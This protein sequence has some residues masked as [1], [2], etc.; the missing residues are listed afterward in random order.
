MA[1]A[2][3][4]PPPVLSQPRPPLW[5]I[6]EYLFQDMTVEVLARESDLRNA[7]LHGPRGVK[8]FGIDATAEMLTGGRAAA[9][10][11][12]YKD[13]DVTLIR[14]ACDEF[15]A[16]KQHW[17]QE[18]A[19]RFIVVTAGYAE[20]PTVQKEETKQKARY[21]K[22][23]IE[24]ELW[25]GT[26]IVQ[27]IRKHRDLVHQFLGSNDWP[28]LLCG[29]QQS[30]PVHVPSGTREL[31]SDNLR[32]LLGESTR[33]E[34]ESLRNALRRGR[35]SEVRDKLAALR[36]NRSLWPELSPEIQASI[37]RLQSSL[38]LE[39]R[40]VDEAE[41]LLA[42]AVRLYPAANVVSL[43]TRIRLERNG[44]EE[45]LAALPVDAEDVETLCARGGTL[46]I[47]SR[48]D[49]AALV[50]E[51]ARAR[52][53]DDIDAIRLLALLSAM[54]NDTS[55]AIALA[56]EA[57]KLAPDW[58]IVRR[59][60]AVVFYLSA[61]SSPRLQSPISEMPEPVDWAFV[62][63][64]DESSRRLIEASEVFGQMALDLDRSPAD[65][66]AL[67][68]WCLACIANV[69]SRAAAAADYCAALI[70]K[71]PCNIYAVPWAIARSYAVDFDRAIGIATQLIQA[72]PSDVRPVLITVT[73]QL[74][75]HDPARAKETLLAHRGRFAGRR[76]TDVWDY[77]W[78]AVLL[79]SNDSA[80]V[81]DFVRNAAEPGRLKNLEIAA[82]LQAARESR[83]DIADAKQRIADLYGSDHDP[84]LLFLWV[85]QQAS[86]GNWPAIN[87]RI[88]DILKVLPTPDGLYFILMTDF[89][90]R[91]YD[92]CLSRTEK[93][94]DLF[95]GAQWPLD[96]KRLRI[97]CLERSG[98]PREA[99]REAA[100]LRREDGSTG[101]LV[102]FARLCASYGDIET[103][104]AAANE[105]L[106]R[107]DVSAEDAV[108]IAEI[109]MPYVPQVS[110]R[111]LR[112]ANAN[113]IPEDRIVTA[114]NLGQRLAIDSEQ[115]E[116][117]RRL[118]S[119]VSQEA[120]PIKILQEEDIRQ[121]L[122][123]A[124]QTCN[125][126]FAL[127]DSGLT[128]AHVAVDQCGFNL[129]LLLLNPK[130]V[131]FNPLAPPIFFTLHGKR[132]GQ[133]PAVI[134]Q[135]I[136]RLNLDI[137]TIF[138]IH[139]LGLWESIDRGFPTL[140]CSHLVVPLLNRMLNSLVSTQPHQDAAVETVCQL[141]R[142]GRIRVDERAV[143]GHLNE[144]ED[145]D[146]VTARMGVQELR[147]RGLIS[148]A[149]YSIALETLPSDDCKAT[150]SFP[151]NG[152]RIGCS[153]ESLVRLAVSGTLA[154][155]AASFLLIAD[156][157]AISALEAEVAAIEQRRNLSRSIK[158]LV[159]ILGERFVKGTLEAFP[160]TTSTSTASTYGIGAFAELNTF[161]AGPNEVIGADDRC[162]NSFDHRGDQNGVPIVTLRDLVELLVNRG[163][164]D[165]SQT[166]RFNH[167]LRLSNCRFIPFDSNEIVDRLMEAGTREGR[168]QE[169]PE[170]QVMR[171]YMAACL[172]QGKV[173]QRANPSIESTGEMSV[174][175]GF[176]KSVLEALALVW[177]KRGQSD[178]ARLAR[179][180]WLIDSLYVDYPGIL[181]AV[182]IDMPL[183]LR[184]QLAVMSAATLLTLNIGSD[185]AFL[186]SKT[187][188]SA[189]I[190][191]SLF[192][193][194]CNADPDMLQEI[195]TSIRTLLS[196]IWQQADVS[197]R[198]LVTSAVLRIIRTFPVPLR[199]RVQAE[200]VTVPEFTRDLH[201]VFKA[202]DLEFD[203]VTYMTQVAAAL[204]NG[205]ATI[206]SVRLV[207][208]V[209]IRRLGESISD[210]I[211]IERPAK[212]RVDRLRNALWSTLVESQP[213]REAAIRRHR[214][215]FDV[216]DD[217][218]ERLLQAITEAKNPFDRFETAATVARRSLSFFYDALQQRV[219]NNEELME[220]DLTPDDGNA[221]YSFY[222][223]NDEVSPDTRTFIHEETGR[224]ALRVG[225]IQAMVRLSAVPIALPQSIEATFQSATPER[226]T[227]YLHAVLRAGASPTHR[228]HA[229]RL[230]FL[231]NSSP[232]VERLRQWLLHRYLERRAHDERVAFNSVL[233]WVT[234]EFDNWPHARRW[235]RPFRLLFAWAHASHLFA[236]YLRAH[237]PLEWIAGVFHRP[238]GYQA[239]TDLEEDLV[240]GRDASSP[241]AYLPDVIAV[242][243]LAYALP[244]DRLPLPERLARTCK[245]VWFGDSGHPQ[246]Q[247]LE[248]PPLRQDVL[249]SFLGNDHLEDLRSLLGERLADGYGA[250]W[251]S[252]LEQEALRAIKGDG[253]QTIGWIFLTALYGN[254]PAPDV[255]A[256]QIEE[257]LRTLDFRAAVEA[258]RQTE[259]PFLLG[260][261]NRI[262]H[263][264]GAES[265]VAITSSLVRLAEW[266]G[267]HDGT[268]GEAAL[269][270][271][272]VLALGYP[273]AGRPTSVAEFHQLCIVVAMKFRR[274][275]GP[276]R[277]AIDRFCHD[278]PVDKGTEFWPLVLEL[279]AIDR[280]A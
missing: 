100:E 125:Q 220:T 70:S 60:R 277:D 76:E 2:D 214:N 266:Y 197:H 74:N 237:A 41:A 102:S 238:R 95:P 63:R 72:D 38:A 146:H 192:R 137:T 172:A 129:A 258:D 153:R 121:L 219:W 109:L 85:Q 160:E 161:P 14:K 225:E 236:I 278:L 130:A 195:A 44:P 135:A 272:L 200:I 62:R 99:L 222:G 48:L 37:V 185:E 87:E 111:L 61:I 136:S 7:R 209:T 40:S 144:E 186:D 270:L 202:A 133:S 143:D 120:S 123:Q 150:G 233:T 52:K 27:K 163:V 114:L 234:D 187:Q 50:L 53:S 34:I 124:Q 228:I 182:R 57:L 66:M 23:G 216:D 241:D 1:S 208:Q 81:L 11:K 25:D 113:T 80:G 105:L 42:E 96:I 45:A 75:A 260:M 89:Q 227:E 224:L 184:R 190:W 110:R 31:E 171:Q 104:T 149:D 54:R 232:K 17:Q 239:I 147:R 35:R 193:R 154:A 26:I 152:Q 47:L 275:A 77:W 9:S 83:G 55:N 79:V 86:D 198:A 97:G 247:F 43:Q 257:A 118:E 67:E 169:N 164:L 148:D 274:F 49:E 78:T 268:E 140:R 180:N 269:V 6:D 19:R 139:R 108:S 39:T 212:K 73:C 179:A 170:L 93:F 151:E 15:D 51:A 221:F 116:L 223:D 230:A 261:A 92:L 82:R 231:A 229:L 119:L 262:A 240:N 250:T 183:H 12:R 244:A 155:F 107:T 181:N 8:Q 242:S 263:V 142:A 204:T 3:N 134:P 255:A 173:L 22:Q 251:R 211:D 71:H 271:N 213:E 165:R 194:R 69:E 226:Q 174:A 217:V 98:R 88:A 94:R 162:L 191:N 177:S 267:S 28:T 166:W 46:L 145:G 64:D 280:D 59:T 249:G 127:Y 103:A 210:A 112:K 65:R 256:V 248:A 101:T 132:A 4:I 252:T 91:A 20:S 168:L 141:Y 56:N 32:N 264:K 157:D 122:A 273:A 279:R 84:R 21:R 29:P 199:D 203:A 36:R 246:A 90:T 206:S 117:R 68:V 276:C 18:D 245:E 138:L 58:E 259:E 188:Y 265:R 30:T 158:G 106:D 33:H 126:I 178:E 176:R 243:G 218:F 128:P 254:G 156:R 201:R 205:S 189:W 13:V 10:C 215:L 175:V 159:E 131:D 115:A 207:E 167:E 16:N 24:F 235:K 253:P 5:L 196:Q